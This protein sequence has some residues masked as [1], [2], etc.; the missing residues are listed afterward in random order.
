MAVTIETSG[1]QLAVI[2]TEHT[3]AETGGSPDLPV[4][5][6]YQL[7][8]DWAA[9]IAGDTLEVRIYMKA[10]A[11]DTARVL[12]LHTVTGDQ[13]TDILLTPEIPAGAYVKF[14]ITQT[15]GTGRSFPWSVHAITEDTTAA[16]DAVWDEA[17]S[18]HVAAG[19]FGEGVASVQ[20]D[21]TGNVDGSVAS[22]TGAVGSVTGNVGGN[23]TGSIG[24][25]ATT[26]KADVNAEV[27]DVLTTDTFAEPAAVP[28]ATASLKD[29]IGWLFTL[30]R[31]KLTQ[32]STTSTVRNDADSANVA[33]AAVSD[34]GTTFTRSEWT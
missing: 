2:G 23:V 29:K 26:A 8:L 1:A 16:A 22:V 21:V 7:V 12:D 28:A 31:N 10:R 18:G 33:T 14:T 4:G 30:A 32:T 19:S 27:V 15:A 3:L 6:R 17:R 13:A 34:D 9:L 25:L 11:A 5:K 20:G 24:S